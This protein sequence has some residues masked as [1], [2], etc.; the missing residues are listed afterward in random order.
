MRLLEFSILGLSLI[1]FVSG[2]AIHITEPDLSKYPT[3]EMVRE[4]LDERDEVM[5][6][7]TESVAELA[8]IKGAE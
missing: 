7:L 4:A 3:I 1:F 2:F 6:K 5:E 8:K